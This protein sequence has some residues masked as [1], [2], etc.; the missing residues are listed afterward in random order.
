MNRINTPGQLG[1]RTALN[2]DGASAD[3]DHFV[4]GL[5]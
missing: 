2:R 1:E 3:F 5:L 4:R